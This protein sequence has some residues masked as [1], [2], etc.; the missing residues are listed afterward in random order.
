VTTASAQVNPQPLG[1]R[2]AARGPRVLAVTSMWPT[3][4]RPVFGTFIRTQIEALREAGADLELMV[5]D[6][7]PRKLLYPKGV[8][9]VRRRV[10]R[11][12]IDLVHAHFGFVGLVGRMQR[13]VPLVVTFHGSDLLG[14]M[15]AEGRLD[16]FSR[17]QAALGR[18]LAGRIDAAIVQSAQMAAAVPK[19]TPAHVIPHEVDLRLFRPT[20]RAE[21]RASLGLDPDRRYLLFAADPG[22]ATKNFPLAREVTDRLEKRHPGIELLVVWQET[23]ERLA[24]YMS[25][26]DALVFPSLQ[27]GSPN[28]VKQALACNL[29]IVATDVGDVRERLAAVRGCFVVTRRATDFVEALHD[30]LRRG[31]RSDGRER[32]ADLDGPIVARRIIDVYEH[33]ARVRG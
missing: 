33:T 15:G 29:P 7:T 4:A 11:G 16:A 17:A 18:W 19:G 12:D 26:A 3:P 23:Q 9:Q 6:A 30:V 27:E 5:L 21:A 24:L 31:E 2:A 1:P 8:V 20:G 14:D 32:V 25:A 13:R 10:A 28:I 22:R